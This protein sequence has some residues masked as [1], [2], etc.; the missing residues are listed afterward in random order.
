MFFEKY[1]R[2]ITGYKYRLAFAGG[3]WTFFTGG[4][5]CLAVRVPAFVGVVT[6]AIKLR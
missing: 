1:K 5:A 3:F 2:S 4:K 6:N